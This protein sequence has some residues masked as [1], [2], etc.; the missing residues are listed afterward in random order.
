MK[1]LDYFMSLRYRVEIEPIPEEQGGGFS[2]SIPR[3]GRYALC[4]EG[5]TVEEAL[6]HLE[7][8]KKERFATYLAEG[9]VI[10][11]PESDEEDY[12]GR[13]VL[14]IPR[15]LHRELALRAK[16]ND[17]SLNQFVVSLLSS[18]LRMDKSWSIWTS[19]KKDLAELRR[20]HSDLNYNI[21]IHVTE[22]ERRGL[23]IHDEEDARAA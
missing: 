22:P 1:N 16:E 17:V 18:G 12:S 3:L 10:P 19:I 14:R 23:K 15:Y 4:A 5:D 13:F 20:H 2:V 7:E 6:A 9:A 21:Q 11:E 8:V